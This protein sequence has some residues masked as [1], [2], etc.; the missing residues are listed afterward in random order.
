LA[1]SAIPKLPLTFQAKACS[2][3]VYQRCGVVNKDNADLR[4]F[5]SLLWMGCNLFLSGLRQERF[6]MFLT[7]RFLL[8]NRLVLLV[9]LVVKNSQARP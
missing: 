7:K 1:R 5:L 4:L 8:A 6:L 2:A 3:G 9:D